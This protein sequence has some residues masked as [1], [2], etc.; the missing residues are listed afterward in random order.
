VHFLAAITG[1][2]QT[3]EAWLDTVVKHR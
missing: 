3:D 2:K 1:H